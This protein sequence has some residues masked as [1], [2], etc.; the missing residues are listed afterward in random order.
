MSTTITVVTIVAVF[1]LIALSA[2]GF[3]GSRE[4][5]R[6]DDASPKPT[7]IRSIEGD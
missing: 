2:A 7:R 6:A 3:F 5:Q 1:L 4:Q